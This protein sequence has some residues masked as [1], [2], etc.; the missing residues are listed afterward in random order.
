M[1]YKTLDHCHVTGK[2]V[3]CRVDLNVPMVAGR[4]TDMTRINAVIPTI[5]DLRSQGAKIALIAHF[6]RPKGKKDLQY[7][8]EPV[9]HALGNLIG[10][11]VEFVSD[12]IGDV[13]RHAIRALQP[14]QICLLENLRFHEGEEKNDPDFAAELAVLGDVFVN[15][16][17]SVA[18]RAHASTEG[19]THMLPSFA[20]RLMEAEIDALTK[21]LDNPEKPV[22]AIVGGA[23]ISTKLDV[24]NHIVKKVDILVLGG[25]MANTF[26]YAKGIDVGA[27]LHEPDMLDQAKQVINTAKEF[28]CDLVLPVDVLTAKEFKAGATSQVKPV[29]VIQSDDMVLDIGHETIILIKQKLADTKT[30]LWNG[31]MGAFEIMPFDHGTNQVAQFVAQETKTG[32]MVS[33]AGGGDTASALKNANTFDEFTYVSTA[34]GAFLEWLE[35]K[36][37]PAVAALQLTD[38]CGGSCGDLGEVCGTHA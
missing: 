18:H 16:A 7:S 27:S 20:G 25:G 31:P 5:M 9:A 11:D 23:K 10:Q 22:A 2:T 4:I 14:G 38:C 15:D 26:L 6:G 8:L 35:G 21:G 29:H 33:I 13:A 3:L 28:D 37:L 1:T 17:F 36:T 30:I 32:R 19:I 24:L 12:C 34:G